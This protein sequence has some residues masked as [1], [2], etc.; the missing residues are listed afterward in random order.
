MTQAELAESVGLSCSYIS[1]LESPKL[2][3]CPSVKALFTIAKVLGVKASK[4]IDMSESTGKKQTAINAFYKKCNNAQTFTDGEVQRLTEEFIV[5]YTYN[6]NAIEGNTLMLRETDM[7][8]KGLT[9]DQKPLKYHLEAVG[10][11]E[12]F[13]LVSE[14]VKENKE[15]TDSLIKQI[16]YLVLADNKDDRRCLQVCSGQ[17]YGCKART[18]P[19]LYD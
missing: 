14:F 19:A 17:N 1:Q 4:L 9:I 7:V 8:L 11:K 2:P 10:H 3:C 6:S 16:H 5:E 15:I 13:E 18:R 12:A